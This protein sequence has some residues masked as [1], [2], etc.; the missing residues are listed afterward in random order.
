MKYLKYSGQIIIGIAVIVA[1]LV[2]FGPCGNKKVSQENKA[3]AFR[4]DSLERELKLRDERYTANQKEFAQDTADARREAQ[5][6]V[7]DVKAVRKQLL[8]SQQTIYRLAEKLEKSKN[9][10]SSGF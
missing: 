6:A 3:L 10:T 9:D 1:I 2:F 5:A 4:T 8:V 7:N